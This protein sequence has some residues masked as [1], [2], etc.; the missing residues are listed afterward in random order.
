MG[1]SFIHLH[2]HTEF[3][4]LDGAVKTS[5]LVEAA[6]NHNMPAV[7]LTDHGNIFGAVNFF[8]EAKR[9]KIKPIL[10]CE[11]YVAPG[12]RKEKKQ[13]KSE[14]GPFHL[15]LLVKNEK[16]YRNLCELITRSYLEGF[17][18]KPRIDKELL[19][20][21]AEG[22]IALS[23]CLIGEVNHYLGMGQL[24]RAEEVAREYASFFSPG[25]FY[26]E[27]QDHGLS[28][29]KKIIPSIIQISRK[30][31]LPLVATNDVH[32][33][34]KEDAES[35]DIL[36]CIQ[37]N[38][39]VTDPERIRFGSQEFYFKST[40]EMEQ[41]FQEIPEAVQNTTEIAAQCRFD[42]PSS[43][44]FLPQFKAPQG[45][46]LSDYFDQVTR[47][48][49]Q[50]RIQALKEKRGNGFSNLPEYEQR[51]EKELK[52]VKEMGFESYFL[53][54]W[55]LI[56]KAK[57]EDIPV[58]PGRGSAA[59]SLLAYSLGITDIDPIEYGLLFERFLN[60]ERVS[61][62]DIDIDFCGRRR[63]EIISYATERYGRENVC[64]IITFGTMAARQ[65][66]RDAGR[67]LEVP[68]PEV[69]KIAK[70][71]PSFGPDATIQEALK[72][73][74][75]LKEMRDKKE[76]IAH[77]LSVAQKLEGQVRHPSIHAA[78]IVIAPKPM[79][80]FLPLYQSTKGEITTQFPMQDIEEIGL[81]KM[82]LLGLRN[83][84][85]IQ[86]AIEL[87][88]KDTGKKVNLENIPL[89]DEKTFKVFQSGN[90]D[91]VFQFESSGMKDLLR[92][93]K[94]ESFPDLIA[95]NA[96]H[97]PGPL[98]SGM[99]DEFI[100]RK[101]DP[102]RISYEFPEMEPILKETKGLIVYQEQ[103]MR[104]A[105][106][107][108]GFSIAEADILRKAM[109]KKKTGVM[110]AQR[111]RFVQGAKERG[112][113]HAKAQK[114]FENINYF[115][116]YGFNK[117]H[118]AAYAYLAY[119]TAYLKAHYPFYFLAALLTSEAE[120]GAT[121][122]VV[123]YINECK[124]MGINV[125]PPDINESDFN[126]TVVKGNIR[127]GL[128][129]VKNVGE[130]AVRALIRARKQG[131][132]F[133][134]PFQ[135]VQ[136]V[137]SKV[138]NRKVLESLV[139]SGAMDS[140]GWKRSQLFHLV[141]Q[142]IEY[143]HR[144]QKIK[145]SKQN[146]LFSG[147]QMSPSPVPQEVKKMREWNE[148]LSLTYEKDALGF[149]ISGHPLAQYKDILKKLVPRSINQLDGEKNVNAEVKAAG[150]IASIKPIK[151]KKNERMATFILEDLS[152][153]IEV[154][155]FPDTY[156]KYYD[157]LREDQ[158]IWVKGKFIGEGDNKRINLLEVMPLSEAF[159][160][161]AKKMVVRVFLPGIEK[162][163]FEELK[164]LLDKNKGSC[165]V[166]FELETSRSSKVVAQSLEIQGVAPTGE[167]TQSLEKLLGENAVYIEY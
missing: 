13:D 167:L 64:Q 89:D 17:Y 68:L 2:N 87:I 123:K 115:A 113:S 32:Y 24:D 121:S 160:K 110:K 52:L 130:G 101:R 73:I 25:D 140:L 16:G 97:R 57:Q 67:A 72:K 43:R 118:S 125:Y 31:G 108:A 39:K 84:T 77:L 152:G 163:V 129:A 69:D 114:I 85:V 120:R 70:M 143:G 117:S 94:P 166:F 141:D 21:H 126:F 58:G 36:L 86:D 119:R 151:T 10:G 96:L 22:L 47:E 109:G 56:Q 33:L 95:M 90:T 45:M 3:S 28:Q 60:P 12:S 111:Q 139:K 148:S 50:R 132:K 79:V 5:E 104:I 93:Y 158:L 83:L 164:K 156:Q 51:L 161:Q 159:Q 154:V 150:I 135:I 40:E 35:H 14:P 54:V 137:D 153:R 157:H 15:I 106:E 145:S 136:Q 146:L 49:F 149:Y 99:T 65:A 92:R 7:A 20:R 75:Q 81:L 55:D 91:G 74:P 48:S 34:Q 18:Y 162:S 46:A 23:G 127:F 80:E 112:I 37:T 165:P 8:Q 61:L 122:Q 27:I 134:S 6:Y 107:L 155:V 102:Q 44:H 144:I 1:S 147:T 82:D 42:F 53:I 124:E 105:T 133:T 19:S 142:M 9:K 11:V 26:I 38:K 88:E 103:V 63:D 30:L 66:V 29:Q 138:V 71:I 62:P 116:G 128:S 4:I 78:G 76:K 59:G 100:E 98:K 131:G 41:V